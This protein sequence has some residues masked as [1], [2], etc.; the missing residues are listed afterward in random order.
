MREGDECF[1]GEGEDVDQETSPGNA[2]ELVETIHDNTNQEAE[3]EHLVE[4]AEDI[5]LRLQERGVVS[6]PA[7]AGEGLD[8]ESETSEQPISEKPSTHENAMT[9][10]ERIDSFAREDEI[11]QASSPRTEGYED[12][13]ELAQ[14]GPS[15]ES[16]SFQT[17]DKWA[18]HDTQQHDAREDLSHSGD[19][20]STEP[21]TA[22]DA[23]QDQCVEKMHAAEQSVDLVASPVRSTAEN[24]A[25]NEESCDISHQQHSTHDDSG[26]PADEDVVDT[27]FR[28]SS[29][30]IH[31]SDAEAISA[32]GIADAADPNGADAPGNSPDIPSGDAA[33]DEALINDS[34][35]ASTPKAVLH[36]EKMGHGEHFE[37]KPL[38]DNMPIVEEALPTEPSTDE[39]DHDQLTDRKS[40]DEDI[41][42]AVLPEEGLSKDQVVSEQR[43]MKSNGK[44]NIADTINES[45]QVDGSGERPQPEPGPKFEDTDVAS[46]TEDETTGHDVGVEEQSEDDGIIKEKALSDV[47]VDEEQPGS[48]KARDLAQR[49]IA[50]EADE[51]SPIISADTTSNTTTPQKETS[52]N[53]TT[54]IPPKSQRHER[55]SED[56]TGT[57]TT[58]RPSSSTSGDS[59]RRPS[60]VS[61]SYL[62]QGRRGSQSTAAPGSSYMYF[63]NMFRL[64][65]TGHAP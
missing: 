6:E 32:D 33:A 1:D 12:D 64:S 40:P 24:S 45:D 58:K 39:A 14:H 47:F 34:D 43:M 26:D 53:A 35:A 54:P 63:P 3:S 28:E 55:Q 62:N 15:D 16:S 23:E 8:V 46:F 57:P 22:V 7:I 9:A 37:N 2:L 4:S 11:S 56:G 31:D 30:A 41:T 29:A 38:A 5:N 36:T 17:W 52:D 48:S 10:E 61:Y 20:N 49:Q 44:E 25:A 19:D 21:Q 60:G 65:R 59:H 27:E 13:R 42:E 50:L 51:D 18:P